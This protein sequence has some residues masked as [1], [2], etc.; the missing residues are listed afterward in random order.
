[1]ILQSKKVWDS[2]TV[3]PLQIETENGKIK[4]IL[5]YGTKKPDEDLGE[6]LVTPGLIDIHCHGCLGHDVSHSTQEWVRQWKRHVVGE[7]VTAFVPAASSASEENIL[8]GLEDVATVMEEGSEGAE[9]LGIYDEGPFISEKFRGAQQLEYK[10]VPTA[11]VIDRYQKAA[12]GHLIYVMVAP[13]EL[14]G[15]LSVIRYMVSQGIRVAIGHTG[16]DFKTCAAALEAGACSFTHTF[17]GMLGLHHREPGTVGA[18]MYFQDAYAEL[19]GDGVHVRAE[20]A[21]ILARVKG[22]DRLITVTDSTRLKGLEQGWHQVFGMRIQVCEDGVSR[23]ENGTISGSCHTLNEL[24]R[25]EV[26]QAGIP[27]E[28]ALNSVT[29]N[30][31]TMLGFGHRLGYLRP[32]YDADIVAFDQEFRPTAVYLKGRRAL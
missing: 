24:L 21:N 32:Q 28:T 15:D 17:N 29:C 13:E 20:V 10:V 27:L 12:R 19:I 18:A 11:E 1:M 5:P 7:G 25:Y 4:N 2:R 8:K 9:I 23:L 22:K 14:G 30:P 31:A 16:A 3:R 26:Q 6:A